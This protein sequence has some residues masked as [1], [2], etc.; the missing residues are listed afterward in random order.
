MVCS[1]RRCDAKLA[2]ISAESGRSGHGGTALLRS[3]CGRPGERDEPV[4]CASRVF[5]TLQQAET[6]IREYLKLLAE[7]PRRGSRRD[8]DLLPTS[9]ENLLRAIKLQM[10]QL[11]FINAHGEE[12]LKPLIGAATLVDSFSDLPLDTASFINAMQQRRTEFNDFYLALIKINRGDPFFWQQV[13]ELCGVSLE[14]RRSTFVES[15]KLRLG[16]GIMETPQAS[17]TL[18]APMRR[19]AID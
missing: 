3:W 6:Y 19:I 9:K 17:L 7:D 14:T 2:D 16:I 4:R 12:T 18:R 15:F 10:A 5:M 13:Y 1:Y 8:P 11:Y